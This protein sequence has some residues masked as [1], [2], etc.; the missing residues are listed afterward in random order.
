MTWNEE[1]GNN[2]SC[3]PSWSKTDSYKLHEDIPN[4]NWVNARTRMFGILHKG[5]PQQL[6]SY[7]AYN[8]VWKNKSKRHNL[9][10]KKEEAIILARDTF[11]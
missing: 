7:G 8:N 2:H 11:S 5:I 1:R 6:L 4:G 3:A 10:T 9:E